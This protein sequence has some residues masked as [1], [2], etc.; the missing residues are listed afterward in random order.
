VL[1]AGTQDDLVS[2]RISSTAFAELRSELENG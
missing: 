1:F 2:V